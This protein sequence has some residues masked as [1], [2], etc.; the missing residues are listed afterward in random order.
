VPDVA[1]PHA[2]SAAAAVHRNSRR[3]LVFHAPIVRDT[4]AVFAL[5]LDAAGRRRRPRMPNSTP[6]TL[7]GRTIQFRVVDIHLPD[8]H[9]LVL[10]GRVVDESDGGCEGAR[11]VV[12]EVSGLPRCIVARERILR[13]L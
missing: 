4:P 7:V 13:T 6:E 9:E 12:V 11:F 2:P 3:R 1:P 10:E 5:P 8:P